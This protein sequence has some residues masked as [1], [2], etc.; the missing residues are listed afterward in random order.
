MSREFHVYPIGHVRS[1]I[2]DMA[3]APRQGR[4]A[5]LVSEIEIYPQYA[6]ALDG[7]AGRARLLVFTWMDRADRDMRKIVPRGIEG[8]GLTGVLNTRTPNRPNPIGLCNVELV[9]VSGNVLTVR[10]LD[11]IDG[12]PVIDIKPYIRELD[13]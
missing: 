1:G 9:N 6:D 12:T 4:E 11:A 8:A 7:I 13:E 3:S 5:G 2:V 10:G